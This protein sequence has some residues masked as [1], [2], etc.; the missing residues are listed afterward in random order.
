MNSR[1]YSGSGIYRHV[2][3][4]VADPV[5]VA[6]L[7]VAVSTPVVSEKKATVLVKTKVKNETSSAQRVVVK[8]LLWNK[9]FKRAGNGQM[10]IE[11]QPT[12]KGNYKPYVKP[13]VWA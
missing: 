9:S 1:W 10:Q 12:G 4:M 6:H 13:H 7:G 3:M 8:T 5:H 11:L 2:W